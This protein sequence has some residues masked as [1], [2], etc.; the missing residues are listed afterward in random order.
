[1]YNLSPVFNDEQ[2]DNNGIPLVGGQIIFYLAGTSTVTITYIDSAGINAQTSPIILNAR[3]ETANPIWLV[4]GTLYKARLFSSTGVLIREFDNISGIND[5][6]SSISGSSISEWI[7]SLVPVYLSP[8]SFSVAGDLTT[9]LHKYR[10][11]KL[12][13]SGGTCYGTIS[14]ATYGAGVTTVVQTNDGITIDS[15]LSV[16][17]YG[18]LSAENKSYLPSVPAGSVMSFFQ[19]S[20]PVG[21]TQVTTHNNKMLRVVSG[22]GGGSGGSHSPILM[23]KV[24]SHTHGFT[25]GTESANHTHNYNSPDAL[26]SVYGAGAFPAVPAFTG[27]TA[28]SVE[29]TTHTHSGTTNANGSASNWQPYYIDMIL[30]SKD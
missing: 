25:T 17:Q 12:T 30:A 7:G 23:D 6:T 28:S 15:G 9:I 1:M 27:G 3:G 22:A 16:F 11:T 13:V 2:F 5:F 14:S 21:W 4:P 29:S 20:A 26:A 8:T 18:F 24:P 19:A 10:R